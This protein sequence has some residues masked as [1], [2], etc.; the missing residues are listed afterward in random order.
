MSI[1]FPWYDPSLSPDN[2]SRN[3]E[4]YYYQNGL[5]TSMVGY[6]LH[7]NELYLIDVIF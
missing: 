6:N 2:P 1:I 3:L 5:W 7:N 4:I